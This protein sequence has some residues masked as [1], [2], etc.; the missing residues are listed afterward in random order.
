MQIIKGKHYN[1]VEV[2]GFILLTPVYGKQG[3]QL[4]FGELKEIIL[5]LQE[6]GK[7]AFEENKKKY[8]DAREKYVQTRRRLHEV[9]RQLY[10]LPRN[11]DIDTIET[12]RLLKEE[13][14]KLEID[15]YHLSEKIDQLYDKDF[16][17]ERKVEQQTEQVTPISAGEKLAQEDLPQTDGYKV[18]ELRK[19]LGETQAQFAKRFNV[20]PVHVSLWENNKEKPP[21][22]VL[23]L[24]STQSN[25]NEA[26]T[27]QG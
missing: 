1:E 16:V 9:D 24:Q 8:R 18:R 22:E 2:G 17:P 19:A 26:Q 14:R 21:K 3:E 10:I 7:I 23:E 12:K 20:H 6:L 25:T 13:K 11:D 27:V 5:K 4:L 15:L